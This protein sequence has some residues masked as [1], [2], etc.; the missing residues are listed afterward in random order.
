MLERELP[1]GFKYIVNKFKIV[2]ECSVPHESKFEAGFI[3]KVCDEEKQDKFIKSFVCSTGTN[4]NFKWAKKKPS[5]KN[6]K[7]TVLKCSQN[8]RKQMQ[9]AD[10]KM[11]GK[12]AGSGHV[13]GVERHLGKNQDCQTSMSFTLRP[14]AKLN[15]VK[16][17]VST[18]LS[19]WCLTILMK[20]NQQ[21]QPGIF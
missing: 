17:S 7:H 6:W 3:V 5:V 9:V 8:L 18:C 4:F 15:I 13:K 19:T 16:G 2:E 11:A 10:A 21:Q 20:L 14:A 12:G 1:Q